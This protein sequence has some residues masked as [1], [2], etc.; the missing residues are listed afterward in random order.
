[1]RRLHRRR[2]STEVAAPI[3]AISPLASPCPASRLEDGCERAGP[4][5]SVQRHPGSHRHGQSAGRRW[6]NQVLGARA[7]LR[8]PGRRRAAFAFHGGVEVN[9]RTLQEKAQEVRREAMTEAYTGVH[10]DIPILVI[11]LDER[12]AQALADERKAAL[13]EVEADIAGFVRDFSIGWRE[14]LTSQVRALAA[15]SRELTPEE[16]RQHG[17]AFESFFKGDE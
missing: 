2:E 3:P 6:N 17:E 15:K 5:R 7:R 12:I 1:M 4:V 10:W 16:S 8:V 13:E 14:Q 11:E 9:P